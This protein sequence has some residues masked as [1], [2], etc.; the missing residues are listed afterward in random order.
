MNDRINIDQ[1]SNFIETIRRQPRQESPQQID[2]DFAVEQDAD[3]QQDHH[4]SKEEEEQQELETKMKEA[5]EKA[6][7]FIVE[8]EQFK[9]S[10]NVPQGI[11]DN[12]F[13]RDKEVKDDDDFF[14]VTCH[15]DPSIKSKI[16]RGEFVDLK[17]LLPKQ[18]VMGKEEMAQL[19]FK[20]G[21]PFFL[22]TADKDRKISGIRRWEQAFRVYAAVYSNANPSRAAEIWQYVY[23]INKVAS[24]FNWS[25]V[26][27]YDYIFRQMMAV[28]PRRSWAK[29]YT[30]MWNICM[31]DL[32]NKSQNSQNYGNNSGNYSR[33]SGGH[34]NGSGNTHNPPRQ[35]EK[36]PDYCWKFNKGKCKFGSECR[37]IN[38]CSYCDS[39]SHGLNTCP[40]KGNANVP[41]TGSSV[42]V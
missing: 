38:R 21:K 14:H 6:Q 40:K 24:S 35:M 12:P 29:T 18:K 27:E 32:A 30:Q 33:Q 19:V 2:T 34:G 8:A 39:T 1:I 7:R 42:S 31:M 36:K 3:T 13:Y 28:N 22:N 4:M 10:V 41:T 15:L 25:N 9:A 26:C 20:D 16:E 37:F 5:R 11:S 23:V 17:R